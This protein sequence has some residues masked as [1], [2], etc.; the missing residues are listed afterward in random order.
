MTMIIVSIVSI[1]L[2][3]LFGTHI[4][5]VFLSERDVMVENLVRYE[6]EKVN[7]TAYANISTA[8]FSNYEGYA[9]D[10]TRTVTYVQGDG[11]SAES[12]KKVIVE[13]REAGKTDVIARSATYLAKNV[14]YGI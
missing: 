14:A 3:L 13:V 10:L 5:S 9:Y 6:M 2:S 1:P 12:L 8:S 4:E 11:T 7:N